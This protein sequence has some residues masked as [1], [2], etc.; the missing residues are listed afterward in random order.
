MMTRLQA[1]LAFT[2]AFCLP[3]PSAAQDCP[4]LNPWIAGQDSRSQAEWLQVAGELDAFLPLCL[5]STEY[6]A[7]TGA[8]WLNGGLLPEA[9]EALERALLLDPDNG[10]AQIDYAEALY[11]QGQLFAAIELNEQILARGDLPANLRPALES[12]RRQWRRVTRDTSFRGDFLLGYDSNLNGAPDPGQ[13]TLTIAGENV[14]LALGDEFQTISGPYTNIGFTARHR[15]LEP[16]RQHSFSGEVQ[17]RVSNDRNTDLL[18]FDGR[19]NFV[20]PRRAGSWQVDSGFRSL[21]FGGSALFTS[22]DARVRYSISPVFTCRPFFDAATQYQLFHDQSWLNAFDSR[23]GSGFACPLGNEERSF[24]NLGFEAALLD[25]QAIKSDRPGGDRRGWQFAANW[26]YPLPQGLFRAVLNHTRLEDR[27]SYSPLLDGG[28]PRW[29][30]RSY[31]L[32]QYRH[33]ATINGAPA[34]VL[35]NLYHQQQ[36]SNIGLFDTSDTTF[37]VGFS[38]GF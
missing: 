15:L 17:G 1:T 33:G 3:L 8:A 12:R 26:Q 13:V 37:E 21:A 9:A 2:L 23:L 14:L 5:E 10:A 4:D 30:N 31:A 34:E 36:D 6:F 16:G 22:A 38:F 29:L 24:G 18:Q 25:S 35:I 27:E 19:Y 28:A 32:L 7:L 11:Q 20:R